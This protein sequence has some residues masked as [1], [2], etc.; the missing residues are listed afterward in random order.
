[1]GV[2]DAIEVTVDNVKELAKSPKK[3]LADR[4]L[5]AYAEALSSGQAGKAA[6]ALKDRKTKI[7]EAVDKEPAYKRGGVV[8][9][10]KT[11]GG[12]W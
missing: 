10:K 1:M 12:C 11:S 5:P 8:K 3:Y 2:R 6:A 4:T 7:D 9:A